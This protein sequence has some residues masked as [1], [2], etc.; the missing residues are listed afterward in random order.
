MPREH[1]YVPN[2]RGDCSACRP[3]QNPPSRVAVDGLIDGYNSEGEAD[4]PGASV[5][6]GRGELWR[7]LW[8]KQGPVKHG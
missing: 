3:K 8:G 4:E 2:V 7:H 5:G 1:V 6:K